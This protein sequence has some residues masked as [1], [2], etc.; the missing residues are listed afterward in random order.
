MYHILVWLLEIEIR[1]LCDIHP[2]Q[3]AWGDLY[4]LQNQLVES[5]NRIKISMKLN[6]FT[7]GMLQISI[8]V[9]SANKSPGEK[10]FM[11]SNS[12]PPGTS[13]L[14]KSRTAG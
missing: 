12:P 13:Q 8:T 5:V 2:D 11:C 1:C 14:G 6:D 7:I 4:R 10:A 9:M 3:I